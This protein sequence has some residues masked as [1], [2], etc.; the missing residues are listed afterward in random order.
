[1]RGKAPAYRDPAVHFDALRLVTLREA[2]RIEETHATENER[3]MLMRRACA[4][5]PSPRSYFLLLE[6]RMHSAP[7][8]L[9]GLA[10]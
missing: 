3:E 8:P 9:C 2:G 6:H 1:M 4:R 10:S 7:S 5:T